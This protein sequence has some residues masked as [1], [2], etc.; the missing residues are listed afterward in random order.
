M[1]RMMANAIVVFVAGGCGGMKLNTPGPVVVQETSTSEVI[2]TD[3]STLTVDGFFSSKT[4]AAAEL[5]LRLAKFQTDVAKAE[6]KAA[7]PC[8]SWFMAPSFCYGYGGM[9]VMRGGVLYSSGG[10]YNTVG[11]MMV[12]TGPSFVRSGGGGQNS[13]P[14][15][16]PPPRRRP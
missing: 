6:A 7:N 2:K 13:I 1:F 8:G 9:P 3:S 15:S 11:G 12:R 5:E 10:G 14:R 16:S 4:R